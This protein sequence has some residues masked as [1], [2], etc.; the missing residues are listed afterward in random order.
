MINKS[1]PPIDVQLIGG[2]PRTR[3]AATARS[4]ILASDGSRTIDSST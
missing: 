3:L 1:L 2:L 4:A